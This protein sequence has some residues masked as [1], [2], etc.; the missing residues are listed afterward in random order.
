M[1]RFEVAFS[2]EAIAD[3]ESSFEWGCDHWGSGRAATWYF[4]MR[5]SIESKLSTSPLGYRLA[6][7]NDEYDVEVRE[8]M[9]ERYHVIYNVTG[10]LVTVIHIRGPYGD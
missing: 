1:R 2:N 8:L 6:I 7:D 10:K 9:I 3:L 4:E 5:D